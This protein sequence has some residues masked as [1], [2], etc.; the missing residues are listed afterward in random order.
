[1]A[2]YASEFRT[3]FVRKIFRSLLRRITGSPTTAS[4]SLHCALPMCESLGSGK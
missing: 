4:M 1:M 2:V 3:G